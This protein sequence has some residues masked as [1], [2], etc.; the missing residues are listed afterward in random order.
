MLEQLQQRGKQ[1]LTQ[2]NR[3]FQVRGQQVIEQ[4]ASIAQETTSELTEEAIVAAVD[5][6]INVIQTASQEVRE[7]NIPTENVALEVSVKIM[8]V[9]ELKMKADVPKSEQV[10][11]DIDEDTNSKLSL[12]PARDES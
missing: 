2:V 4:V 8:G 12:S 1:V 9:V 6:A 10:R 7:R 3:V 11:K 5:R